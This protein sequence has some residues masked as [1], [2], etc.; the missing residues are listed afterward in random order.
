MSRD[1]YEI[2]DESS[3]DDLRLVL[4]VEGEAAAT[5]S[6]SSDAVTQMRD[7]LGMT[8][9]DVLAEL[10]NALESLHRNQL[11]KVTIQRLREQTEGSRYFIA[12]YISRDFNKVTEGIIW[13]D[14]PNGTTGPSDVPALVR[15]KLRYD[16]HGHL[17]AGNASAEALR[18]A[19]R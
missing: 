19:L 7:Q 10:R 12:S 3:G 14:L 13:Y 6:A 11:D 9:E 8:R 1:T 17:T 4:R 2:V 5:A 15:N 16:V 18:R